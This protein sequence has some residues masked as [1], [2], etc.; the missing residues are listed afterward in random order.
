[1]LLVFFNF[2]VP[3]IPW[4]ESIGGARVGGGTTGGWE[5][6]DWLK[7]PFGFM[8][9]CCAFSMGPELVQSIGGPRLPFGAAW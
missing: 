8:Q 1:M 5:A 3:T 7:Q 9:Q 4:I 6:K 2:S